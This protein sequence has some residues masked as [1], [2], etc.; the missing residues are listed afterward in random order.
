MMS[1]QDIQPSETKGSLLT[2]IFE[3]LNEDSN[4]SFVEQIQKSFLEIPNDKTYSEILSS[5]APTIMKTYVDEKYA[6]ESEEEKTKA[7]AHVDSIF[8][9]ITEKTSLPVKVDEQKTEEIKANLL[10]KIGSLMGSSQ[11]NTTPD[12]ADIL[13]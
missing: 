8:K 6:D 4:S 13:T 9:A 5:L 10:S 11:K 1:N 7:Q 2:Q 12:F 3:C